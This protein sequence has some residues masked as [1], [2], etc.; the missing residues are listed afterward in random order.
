M[1][2]SI[3]DDQTRLVHI[4]VV[5]WRQEQKY[6]GYVLLEG[7]LWRQMGVEN[8]L[9]V[10]LEHGFQV[11]TEEWE[12][13]TFTPQKQTDK[14]YIQFG[15]RNVNAILHFDDEYFVK[16][17]SLARGTCKRWNYCF[18][19]YDKYPTTLMS[20]SY[21]WKRKGADR[22]KHALWFLQP[23]RLEE[24]LQEEVNFYNDT[25]QS[26]KIVNNY[27]PPELSTIINEYST[28]FTLLEKDNTL[29]IGIVALS[30]S[31]CHPSNFSYEYNSDKYKLCF[32]VII[33]CLSNNKEILEHVKKSLYD[34]MRFENFTQL[35]YILRELDDRPEWINKLKESGI[36]VPATIAAVTKKRKRVDKF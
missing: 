14:L 27:L 21:C 13:M 20:E 33:Q 12:I 8:A 16:H 29:Q 1:T 3:A 30:C 32:E 19:E 2:D 17:T 28:E 9:R 11:P 34:M 26:C 22:W 24:I 4:N 5:D 35:D 6:R 25:K 18:P 15:K 31:L 23:T 10:K 36:Y 7:R